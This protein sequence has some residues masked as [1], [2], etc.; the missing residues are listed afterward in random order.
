MMWL[1]IDIGTSGVKSVIL[2]DQGC[3]LAQSTAPLSA[4]RPQPLWSEQDPADW[5]EAVKVSILA[6]P[7]NFR[8]GIRGIGLSGQ[9]H[10]AVVLGEVD[11]VLR[12]AILWNDGRSAA[13]GAQLDASARKYTGNLAMPGFTAPKLAWLRDNE[14]EISAALRTVLLPKDYIRMIL[15]GDKVSDMSDASGTL[16]LDVA[17]RRWSPE[18]LGAVGL[19]ESHMPRLVEGSEVSGMLR[20]SVAD[21]LGLPAVP[22]AGGGGDQAAGAIGAGV[23]EPGEAFLSLGTS[24]VVFAAGR[25]FEPDPE[26]GVHAFCH[27]LPD[28]WHTM[29]V[30]LSA[31]ACLDWAARLTG[32][33]DVAGAL[34]AAEASKAAQRDIPI[35]LPY[36]SGERTP[37]NDPAAKGVF[38][39]LTHETGPAQLVQSVLE[40]VAFALRDGL[41]TMASKPSELSV[42]GGGA[43]SEYWAKI[44]ADALQIPLIYRDGSSVGPASGA[45]RLARIAV[46]QEPIAEVCTPPDIVAE[47]MP[48][49]SDEKRLALFRSLYPKLKSS[50]GDK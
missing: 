40:G 38:F 47:V 26:R 25:Q 7:G 6:L 45:A 32:F 50:F 46:D 29:S 48:Q 30:M 19:D 24:G 9:M 39:N 15:T 4:Q 3:V 41:D 14:P 13:Q 33:E 36:L 21:E 16:W 17:R 18:M 43:R 22:V 35:F 49:S 27:A 1:G 5:W 20:Q 2:C 12:P 42:I 37:H 31:A 34:A 44:L 23:T 28:R 11:E 8:A 10:G